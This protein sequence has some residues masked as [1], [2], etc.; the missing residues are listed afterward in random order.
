MQKGLTFKRQTHYEL[1]MALQEL[2][3]RVNRPHIQVGHGI[4][5]VIDHCLRLRAERED[6]PY[7]VEGALIRVNS[8]D[9]QKRLSPTF[10]D[11]RG[12]VVFRF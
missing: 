4:H 11:R 12:K 6:F 8:L 9:L 3:L 5:E 10:G 2:G 1:M 7:P